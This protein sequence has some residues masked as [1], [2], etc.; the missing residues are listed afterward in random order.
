VGLYAS[1]NALAHIC[2]GLSMSD[3]GDLQ[4]AIQQHLDAIQSDPK[5]V[6]TDINLIQLYARI[7]K[8]DKAEQAYRQAV[9][10]NPNRTDCYYN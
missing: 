5:E 10:L 1:R 7:G 4:G 3:A 8:D 9:A 6:Q 2:R